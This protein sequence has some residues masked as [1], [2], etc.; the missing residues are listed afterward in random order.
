VRLRKRYT[1]NGVLLN[2]RRDKRGKEAVRADY[3]SL[4]GAGVFTTV[5]RGYPKLTQLRILMRGAKSERSR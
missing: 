4:N 1:K 3:S 2:C 5:Y